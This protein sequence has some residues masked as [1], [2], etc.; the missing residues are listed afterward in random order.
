M[1]I[2]EGIYDIREAFNSYSNDSEL[3]NRHIYFL[4]KTARRKV[5]R[6]HI[7]RKPGEWRDQMT[8][9]IV[10]DLEETSL[11]YLG[12]L[13]SIKRTTLQVPPAIGWD[14]FKPYL[15]RPI[16]RLS[17]EIELLSKE[18]IVE[19]QYANKGFIYGFIDDD[20]YL[21]LIKPNSAVLLTK[22][23][24]TS[25]LEDPMDAELITGEE[26]ED[27]Y[28]PGNMWLRVKEMVLAQLR[29]NPV[30]DTVNDGKDIQKA[31]TAK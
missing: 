24:I 1:T 26:V 21:Y 9:T 16:D 30:L 17:E 5:V 18:R 14:I 27:F 28:L 29:S 15:V 23:A 11:D 3:S 13:G 25:I 10:F 8:Q 19:I 31:G 7:E 20:R 4:M 2:K 12:T 22:V 6:E